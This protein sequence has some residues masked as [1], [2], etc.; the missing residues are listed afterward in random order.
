LGKIAGG[1]YHEPSAEDARRRIVSFFN[2]HLK[3]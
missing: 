2:T 3:A 1:G